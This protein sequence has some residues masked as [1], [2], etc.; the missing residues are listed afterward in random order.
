[1][2]QVKSGPLPAAQNSRSKTHTGKRKRRRKM[3]AFYVV[4][5]FVLL[6]GGI[7]LFGQYANI[8]K[9]KEE[10]EILKRDIQAAQVINEEMQRTLDYMQT[11]EYIRS[12]AREQLGLMLPG[13]IRFIANERR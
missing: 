12:F 11:D 6:I 3:M 7:S 9:Q 2:A 13:E 10:M 4:C 5:A 1:M 8:S